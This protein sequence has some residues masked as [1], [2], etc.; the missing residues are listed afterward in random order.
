MTEKLHILNLED[1]RND[2]ELL[3]AT[4][5]AYGIACDLV[6]VETE[7]AYVGALKSGLFD[8]ILADY[9]LP[10]FDGLSALQLTRGKYDL[11]FVFVSGEIGEDLAIEAVRQ[12]ATDYVLKNRLDK[13]GP[14][15]KRAILESRERADR[16]AAEQELLR[17]KER[18]QSTLESITD[19][20]FTLDREWRFTYVNTETTRL[21]RQDRDHL[22]GKSFWGVCPAE[23]GSDFKQQFN[24]VL[25][26]NAAIAFETPSPIFGAWAEVRVYPLD[27]G[28]SVYVHDITER[29][30]AEQRLRVTNDLLKL[31]TRKTS[32][33]EYLEEGV[34]L[35]RA[36]SGCRQVGVRLVD[37][38]G[39]IPYVASEGFSTE[40][41]RSEN[42]LT[43]G[44]DQCVCTRV[45]AGLSA[46]RGVP[47]MTDNGSFYSNDFQQ[48]MSGL[49]A[50]ERAGFRD[51]CVRSGFTTVG[52]IPVKYREHILG[53]VHLT[54]HRPGLLPLE[55]V[56]F[57]ERMAF[58]IGEAV[59]RFGIEEELRTNYD[60]LR[61]S[62]ARY[63]SLI[64]GVHDI[65]FTVNQDGAIASLSPAFDR[66]SGYAREEWINRHFTELVHPED[67]SRAQALFD[68]VLNGEVLPL[69]ELRTRTASGEYR[70]MEFKITTE[71]HPGG[72]IFGIA[73]DITERKLAEEERAR[74]VS[75]IESAVEAVVIT[76]PS[77]GV[78]QY[79]NP[80]FEQMTGYPKEEAVGRTLHFLESGRHDD[81]YYSGLRDSLARDGSWKGRLINKKKDGALYF[82][83][84]TVSPVRNQAGEIVNYVYLK[85]DVT[86][87]LRLEAI[88]ESVN[89]MDNIGYIFSGVRH[90]IGN[91]INSLNMVLGILREKLDTLQPEAVKTYLGRMAEQVERVE[92]I[93]RSL[94]SFNLYETQQPQNVRLSSFMDSF[95][96]LVRSDLEKKGIAIETAF[97][98]GA[99]WVT[100]DPRALQQVLLNVITNAV[101]AVDGRQDPAI[102]ISASAPGGMVRIR[103]EDN[104]CGI[105]EDKL[106]NLFKPFY[107]SKINGTGLGLVIVRKMLSMMK[108]GIEIE[109]R[110]GAGTTVVISV[111][112]G[113]D[114]G[115]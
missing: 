112:E 51:L 114:E 103:V 115:R 43:I 99:E 39:C 91:P 67:T 12:G 28:V 62:E 76:A 24:R 44:N 78:I 16:R 36:W 72:T 113:L 2:S 46:Q 68:R 97:E 69:F 56:E 31:F 23:A 60:A 80:A 86:E 15:V 37:G 64:E 10:G 84:C 42:A 26:E 83:D 57:V 96:P 18:L 54:D 101:D 109:S 89:A 6:R 25:S 33:K 106:A 21:F 7:Q 9:S 102:R 100:A 71:R 47:V 50:D 1:S 45:I 82:E 98:P 38:S 88:A 108:G 104:G 93:L 110:Q 90:E 41:L 32:L 49:T 11:P 58:I 73:R 17:T 65:I 95:L 70:H 77:T 35:I 105:P 22:L 52:V 19:A 74:L 111:P 13:L 40:F 75:A 81:A 59:Y 4:L 55:N 48:F 14:A 87:K 8:F 30:I 20:F 66:I 63:R 94:K 61:D 92:Y 5:E 34:E 79:V 3:Q 27:N 53:A 85:R 107:T 29:K